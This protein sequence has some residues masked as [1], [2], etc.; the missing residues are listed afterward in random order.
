MMNLSTVQN[1]R[2][3]YLIGLSAIALLVT[4]S[5]VTMQQVVSKQRDFSKIVNLAGHQAGLTNRIA[6]F[7][8]LMAA[9]EDEEEF[10]QAQAQVGRSMNKMQ[11]AHKTLRQGDPENNIP[12]LVNNKLLIIYDDPMVGLESAL[13]SFLERARQVYDTD[14]EALHTGSA[15]Y[16]F[17]ITYGPHVLEPLL[18]A[19]V[20]EYENISR[21]AIVKIERFELIIWLAAIAALLLELGFI[22]RPLEGQVQRALFSLESSVKE[23]TKTRKRLLAAQKL[24]LVGDWE[25]DTRTG[26]FTCSDQIYEICGMCRNDVE[27]TWKAVLK[28]V[29][30]EDRGMVTKSLRSLVEKQ[31]AL[32]LEYRIKGQDGVERLVYQHAAS[33]KGRDGRVEK[34]SGAVQDITERK[35]LS[36]KLEKL[37][38]HIPGFIFQCQLDTR[39]RYHFSYVSSG[40]YQACGITSKAME[41]EAGVLLDRIHE[42]DVERVT[43]RV[44]QSTQTLE[45]WKSQFRILHPERGLIWLEGHATPERM[46]DG[47]TLWYGYIWDVTERKASEDQIKKLALY[48]ALTGLAN[49]RLLMDRLGHAIAISRRKKNCG[50]VL[51]LDMD[52]FKSL[53]DTKGHNVGDALLVEVAKRLQ[54]CVRETDTV[55]RLGGD[56]FVVLLEWLGQDEKVGHEKAMAIAE[57][58]KGMLNQAYLLGREHHLH[59][60]SASIGV[61]LFQSG[62]AG[63]GEVLKR[64]DVAMYEAKDRGRNRVCFYSEARQAM[65]DTRAAM[66]LDMQTGLGK[67]EFFLF[68]QPQFLNNG[69]ICGAEALLRWMPRGKPPVSPEL[70]IPIAESTDLILLLGEWVMEKAC[71]YI[72]DLGR[73][74]L[75][76]EF[77]IGVNISARQFVDE[78]FLDKMKGILNRA[79][80]DPSRLKFELTETCLIQDMERGRMILNELRLMGLSV[81]LDDF[82]TG[83]S[84]LN[85]IKNLPLT[86]LKLDRSLI[87]GIENQN[88]NRAIVKAALAMAKAM[89]LK[90]IAEGVETP[91]QMDFLVAQGCDMVQGFLYARP[92]PYEDF[93]GFLEQESILLKAG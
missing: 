40:V 72:K 78:R 76:K 16:L 58:I 23:M 90:T 29:H 61:S 63:E 84:S 1:L 35:E 75:P 7:A 2:L 56:E 50:A 20:D 4:A 31:G 45:T 53:N 32:S 91:T 93:M 89:S 22:F 79:G 82:G 54:A 46:T 80:I 9:T 3:R 49:R 27:L 68:L 52:N 24:A 5:F 77:A 42:Q 18:D 10:K 34:V 28:Q 17:L 43:E 37:S 30:P 12:K 74:D 21:D 88:S 8:S 38:G 60:S 44:N 57:K 70:F 71:Q 26:K 55:A 73:Y 33:V 47:G 66:A 67:K 64:A 15:P 69:K 6:Y 39:G 14:M 41:Q 48:D 11:A 19:A 59:H 25:L 62:D 13:G 86:T 92:M 81:E 87:S 36:A 51:M 65:V 85:S 83:Y